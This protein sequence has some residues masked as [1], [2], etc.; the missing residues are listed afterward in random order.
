[1]TNNTSLVGSPLTQRL[2]A[3][4]LWLILVVTGLGAVITLIFSI[5]AI[6]GDLATRSATLNLVADKPLPVS[7]LGGSTLIS[8]MAPTTSPQCMSVI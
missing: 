1:M 6:V 4:S 2:N 3:A 7:A 5:I 8:R